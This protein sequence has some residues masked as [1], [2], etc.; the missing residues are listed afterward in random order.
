MNENAAPPKGGKQG[1][2]QAIGPASKPARTAGD[3]RQTAASENTSKPRKQPRAGGP[4]GGKGA[5][6]NKRPGQNPGDQKGSGPA[7]PQPAAGQGGGAKPGPKAQ[8]QKQGQRPQGQATQKLAAP[9]RRRRR[10]TLLAL[11]FLLW[12]MAPLGGVVWYLYTVAKDQYASYVGFAVRTEEVSS[13]IEILG[14]ITELSGNSGSDTDILYQF[15]QSRQMIEAVD[16]RLN[17]KQIYSIE[18]DPVFALPEDATIEDMQQYWQ[19]VVKV[20]YDTR[21][22][23]LELRVVAFSAPEAQ[24]VAQAIVDESTNIINDLTAIARADTTRYA[25]DELTR[26]IERLKEARQ[27]INTFR[28]RTQIVDPL[29]DTQGHLGL[30]NNLQTQLATALIDLDMIRLTAR[31]NDP[32]IKQEERR[33]HVIRNRISEERNRFG[34]EQDTADDTYSRLVGEYEALA[35]DLEFANK[36]YLSSLAAYDTALAEAQRKS[37]YLAAYVQPTLAQSAE[38]P[39][40]LLLSLL[41]GGALLLSWLVFCLIY[42]SVRDRR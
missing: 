38:Y 4:A 11:T 3:Q 36:S 27:A 5:G 28:A 1:S 37:R 30:L 7:R 13:G 35:V 21:S 25:Q 24:Q 8:P 42:Y 6:Q 29:A 41:V 17:L 33:V 10:H 31:E 26:S 23:L 19:R 40:R 34:S 2:E 15:I 39:Q 14:G 9:A 16:A 22:G 18:D 12:V 32:R 20:F